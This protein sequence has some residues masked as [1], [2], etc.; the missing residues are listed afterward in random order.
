MSP[1]EQLSHLAI[2]MVEFVSTDAMLGR[3]LHTDAS[4]LSP[5][6]Q[7]RVRA[8]H[9]EFANEFM[10]IYM[11]GVHSGSLRP[12]APDLAGRFL[13]DLMMSSARSVIALKEPEERLPEV[14]RSM[15]DF[16]LHG[17]SAS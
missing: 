5:A 17:L 6:A 1:A 14:T 2:G 4:R 9:S 8:T 13:Q 16:M 10:R 3:I 12:L 7:L 15:V 11:E